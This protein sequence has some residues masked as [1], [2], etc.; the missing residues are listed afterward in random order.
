MQLVF[1]SVKSILSLTDY[2]KG[3]WGRRVFFMQTVDGV[4]YF[5]SL[6]NIHCLLPYCFCSLHLGVKNHNKDL[7]TSFFGVAFCTCAFPQCTVLN[8]LPMSRPSLP[9]RKKKKLKKNLILIAVGLVGAF[10]CL[11]LAWS[12]LQS[13]HNNPGPAAIQIK[14]WNVLRFLAYTPAFLSYGNQ[15]MD[16]MERGRKGYCCWTHICELSHE[17]CM[18][19]VI[20][21]LLTPSLLFRL[22]IITQITYILCSSKNTETTIK[23]MA[24]RKFILWDQDTILHLGK[25][26][27]RLYIEEALPKLCY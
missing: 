8:Y 22:I 25:S 10:L 26:I 16:K 23:R 6:E 20:M 18:S 12:V 3:W 2:Q 19:F 9:P 24:T 4:Q 27:Y 7:A 21:Y 15:S 11:C 13:L 17:F 5:Q 1:L 14:G